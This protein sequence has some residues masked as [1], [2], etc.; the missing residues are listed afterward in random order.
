MRVISLGSGS[1]GNATIVEIDGK[2]LLIDNGFTL[3]ETIK[4]MDLSP[5]EIRAV[6]LTHEHSDHIEGVGA[7]AKAYGL[8]VH[9]PVALRNVCEERFIDCEIITHMDTPFIVDGV[10]V[11]PFR[12]PHDAKY[13][14]GY[15]F[16][17]KGESFACATDLG[18]ARVP[19]LENLKGVDTV[20]LESN[21]DEDMLAGGPY[22]EALKRR[23]A[24]RVG[25]LSNQE[26]A[27]VSEFLALNGTKKIILAHLS[28]NNNAPEIAYYET[29]KYLEKMV[30]KDLKI[31]LGVAEQDKIKIF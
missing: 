16:E 8:P 30:D 18:E 13:T 19:V 4:R 22:P 20:L 21:Y 1:K 28:E 6:F 10:T 2:Y 7:L 11:T 27:K 24:S 14:V 25:H 12:V 9:V 15:K 17:A 3:R 23:I 31:V 29:A 26:S 5:K